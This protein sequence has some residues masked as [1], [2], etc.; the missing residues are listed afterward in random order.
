MIT[1][2]ISDDT[3]AEN[4]L[5]KLKTYYLDCIFES[6]TSKAHEATLRMHM[7][8]ESDQIRLQKSILA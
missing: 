3:F 8:D 1:N 2:D 4:V 7:T 6:D 5:P